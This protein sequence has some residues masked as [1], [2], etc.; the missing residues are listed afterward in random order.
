LSCATRRR[1]LRIS[2]L[3]ILLICDTSCTSIMR[4]PKAALEGVERVIKRLGNEESRNAKQ[5]RCIGHLT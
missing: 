3:F 2:I 5:L 1:R 4:K